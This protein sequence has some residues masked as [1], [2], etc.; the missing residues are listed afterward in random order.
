MA[1][2]NHCGC[3]D[4]KVSGKAPGNSG[5]RPSMPRQ[6]TTNWKG[7]PGPKGP[8]WGKKAIKGF[9]ELSQGAAQDMADD[10][11]AQGAMGGAAQGASMGCMAG[12]WGCVIGGAVGLVA[13]GFMG[14]QQ[15]K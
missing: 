4:S 8:A 7:A 3:G 1:N 13:G 2:K 15:E 6:G 9:R 5:V 10:F 12:P 14:G 11:S